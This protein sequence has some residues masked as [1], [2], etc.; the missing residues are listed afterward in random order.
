MS[1]PL[2]VRHC[3]NID[4]QRFLDPYETATGQRNRQSFHRVPT[5][6]FGAGDA[7]SY[8]VPACL[9]IV[10]LFRSEDIESTVMLTEK[11]RGRRSRHLQVRYEIWLPHRHCA[12]SLHSSVSFWSASRF[13]AWLPA[14]SSTLYLNCQSKEAAASDPVNDRPSSDG[15]EPAPTQQRIVSGNRP[16]LPALVHQFCTKMSR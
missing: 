14:L 5:D 13:L 3:G 1:Y 4:Q 7:E 8:I 15:R 6:V 2:Q 11:H 12:F 9:D 10:D 16:D